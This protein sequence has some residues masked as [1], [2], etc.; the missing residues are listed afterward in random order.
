MFLP[1][2]AGTESIG[3]LLTHREE[4]CNANTVLSHPSDQA[5]VQLEECFGW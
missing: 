3:C 4:Q 5:S 2:Q 1:P